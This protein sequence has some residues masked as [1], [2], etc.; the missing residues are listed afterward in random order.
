M[1]A[2]KSRAGREVAQGA[3]GWHILLVAGIGGGRVDE[4]GVSPGA[5]LAPGID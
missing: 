4:G 1:A 3:G 5:L 2:D